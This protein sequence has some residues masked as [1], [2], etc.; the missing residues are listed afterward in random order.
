MSQPY[1][2]EVGDMVHYY[3]RVNTICGNVAHDGSM[4]ALVTRVT[5]DTVDLKLYPAGHL[6]CSRSRV[7]WAGCA[8]PTLE[9][10][11]CCPTP[12]SDELGT[13]LRSTVETID[14]LVKRVVALEEQTMQP[15]AERPRSLPPSHNPLDESFIGDHG[16]SIGAS[17]A[18]IDA[19]D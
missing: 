3:D 13:C 11:Y 7:A 12:R 8:S 6:P 14:W 5:G 10:S 1:K 9:K 2:P 18:Q 4:A 15:R 19:G 16:A 17:A